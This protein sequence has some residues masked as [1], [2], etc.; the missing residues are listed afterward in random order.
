MSSIREQV[1]VAVMAALNGG[2]KPAGVPAAERTRVIALEV[3][4][5]P[6]IVLV[7]RRESVD[8]QG[9]RLGPLVQRRLSVELEHRAAG[10]AGVPADQ[11]ADALLSWPVKALCGN[12]LGGLAI[13]IRESG[14][15]WQYADGEAPFV[16]ATQ[17]FEVAYTTR[18]A[19][20]E[21]RA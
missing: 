11:A 5:L 8:V 13:E 3:S 6:S 7:P 10:G 20:A 14:T 9:G 21:Q 18:V 12:T 1:L 2:G 16:L 4:Q 19:D 15:E 17:T